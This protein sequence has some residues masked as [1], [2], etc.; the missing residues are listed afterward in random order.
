MIACKTITDFTVNV[1]VKHNARETQL[2][3]HVHLRNV[4]EEAF[5]NGLRAVS[6]LSH[7]RVQR[8]YAPNSIAKRSHR[9]DMLNGPTRVAERLWKSF[10]MRAEGEE[11]WE[12]TRVQ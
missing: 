4:Q 7:A 10:R 2:P 12:N 8:L 9:R 3:M 5:E 11:T 1:V 6:M